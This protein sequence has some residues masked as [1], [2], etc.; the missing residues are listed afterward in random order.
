MAISTNIARRPGSTVYYARI[1][2]PPDLQG[3]MKKRELWK[4]LRTRDPR[5][6][7]EKVLPVLMQWRGE[8]AELRKR[9]EPTPDDLQAAVWSQYEGAL[10]Q[11]RHARAAFPTAATIE[12]A[13]GQLRADIEAGRVPWS[14]EP[15]VQLSAA[16][17]VMVMRDAAKLDRERRAVYLRDLKRRRNRADL[18]L[19]RSGD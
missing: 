5:E 4:S 16:L 9:R 8:F 19:C 10:E 17:E 3:V 14:D 12:A 6:A 1:G 2:V 11:D 13:T 18:A 15:L 7:R